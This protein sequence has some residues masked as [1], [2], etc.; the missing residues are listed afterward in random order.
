MSLSYYNV[1]LSLSF[2]LV[3]GY[4]S[5]KKQPRNIMYMYLVYTFQ[6]NIEQIFFSTWYFSGVVLYVLNISKTR[7]FASYIK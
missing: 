1:T 3:T 4:Y 7:D 6:G 2:E 5:D